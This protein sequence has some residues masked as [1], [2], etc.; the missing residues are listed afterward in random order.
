MPM[1]RLF[2]YT[3][4]RRC[5]NLLVTCILTNLQRTELLQ[6]RKNGHAMITC[7][8]K[9]AANED[10]HPHTAAWQSLSMPFE[11]C[12]RM[13]NQPRFVEGCCRC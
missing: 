4:A 2:L 11:N 13:D 9:C 7:R 1:L 10:D 3:S 6:E 12:E 5:H 8:K